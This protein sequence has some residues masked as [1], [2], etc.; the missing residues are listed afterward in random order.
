MEELGDA[1]AIG[2]GEVAVIDNSAAPFA[3]DR[4]EQAQSEDAHHEGP[5][6]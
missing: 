5:D 4:N 6:P 3:N 2:I 1:T